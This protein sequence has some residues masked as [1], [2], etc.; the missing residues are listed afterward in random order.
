MKCFYGKKGLFDDLD[1]RACFSVC[2]NHAFLLSFSSGDAF[3]ER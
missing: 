3:V 2:K 1:F